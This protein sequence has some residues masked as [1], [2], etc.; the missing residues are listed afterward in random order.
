MA[1]I[2]VTNPGNDNNID[3]NLQTAVNSANNGD[4]VVIPSGS[5]TLS[6]TVTINKFVSI[7]GA[8]ISATTLYRSES[9]PD[10]QISNDVSMLYYNIN[11]KL[12]SNIVVADMTLK[13]KI[14]A[15]ISGGTGSTADDVGIFFIKCVDFIVT[16]CRFQYFGDGGIDI[17]HH[18]D[19]A[20][21]LIYGNQFYHNAKG[22]D[23]SGLGY[24]IA[25]YGENLKWVDKPRFGTSN[26][27]FIEDNVFNFHRHSIAAG[28][29]ALYVAR[30]NNI[31]DN[32]IATDSSTH[33]IDTHAGRGGSL[34]TENYF[35]SR[36]TEI[37][38]NTIVNTTF[39]SGLP[40][41]SGHNVNEVI[42][43]AI[44]IRGGE[45][46]IFNNTI[47]GYRFGCGAHTD[48]TAFGTTYP[49]PYVYGYPSGSEFG[50]GHTGTDSRR[51]N[52]DMFFWNNTF[53]PYA[54]SGSSSSVDF[55]IYD[56]QYFTLHRDFHYE[57]KPYYLPYTYPHPHRLRNIPILGT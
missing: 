47:S 16:R 34:G 3:Y 33:A 19:L 25:I 6:G 4:I 49:L 14:P 42:E 46:L 54:Y 15:T 20:R 30:Y 48:Y 22:W 7:Q 21:G 56:S 11:S 44:G 41:V 26:F 8:G 28:G 35:G 52:G 53:T 17:I 45:S 5:F 50:T 18:D 40:I 13:S 2:F 24:G 1:T 12:S 57:A 27:I 55:W 36:A 51:A 39:Y 29:N 9:I 10:N 23:G 38:N 43:L 32:I 37:Y 31:G